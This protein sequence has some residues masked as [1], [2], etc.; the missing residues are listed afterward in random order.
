MYF[1]SSNENA[2]PDTHTETYIYIY[3]MCICI[4]RNKPSCLALNA[5]LEGTHTESLFDPRLD[6]AESNPGASHLRIDRPKGMGANCAMSK[7]GTWR[8]QCRAPY[9]W[10]HLWDTTKYTHFSTIAMWRE[11]QDKR[12]YC[13]SILISWG[14]I[15]IDS[16]HAIMHEI[17]QITLSLWSLTKI[18]IGCF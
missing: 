12:P 14:K 15:M 16:C 10:F 5:C 8:V 4:D 3:I 7:A 9:Y 2:L 6:F 17:I 18:Y 13:R 11:T 1:D